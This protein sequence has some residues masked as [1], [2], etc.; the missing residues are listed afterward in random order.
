MVASKIKIKGENI[1]KLGCLTENLVSHLHQ[2]SPTAKQKTHSMDFE[3]GT[4]RF[5][6]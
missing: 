1:H 3:T 5:E 4:L 2:L 6:S